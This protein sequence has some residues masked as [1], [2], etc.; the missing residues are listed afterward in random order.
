M[1]PEQQNEGNRSTDFL[2]LLFSGSGAQTQFHLFLF[3]GDA[4]FVLEDPRTCST[5]PASFTRW[6]IRLATP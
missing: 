5:S 3:Y 6:C 1:T 2:F 4:K